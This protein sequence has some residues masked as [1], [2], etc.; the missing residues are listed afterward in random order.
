MSKLPPM[1]ERLQGCT[2]SQ[3]TV[4]IFKSEFSCGMQI[5]RLKLLHCMMLSVHIQREM[6][7]LQERRCFK[8]MHCGS[9]MVSLDAAGQAES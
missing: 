5:N 7:C 2:S 1:L 3:S 4:Y 9:P 6:I 8:L